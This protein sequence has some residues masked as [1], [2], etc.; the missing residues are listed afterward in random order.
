MGLFKIKERDRRSQMRLALTGLML[1]SLAACSHHKDSEQFSN[2][3]GTWHGSLRAG[4]R[5][6]A[7]SVAMTLT[8]FDRDVAGTLTY[9]GSRTIKVTGRTSYATAD[10]SLTETGCPN[11][12]PAAVQVGSS[13]LTVGFHGDTGCGLLSA[14]GLLTH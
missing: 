2:I 3:A 12:V 10:L 6:P 1:L 8:Q 11:A 9:D 7:H 14:S 13:G 4:D 5:I